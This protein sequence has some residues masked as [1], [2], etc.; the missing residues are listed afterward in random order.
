MIG[1][2]V[3]EK[4]M[5]SQRKSK[6]KPLQQGARTSTHLPF[7]P[8]RTLPRCHPVMSPQI[9]L[10]RPSQRVLAKHMSRRIYQIG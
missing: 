1:R 9:L 5:A 4:Q 6:S 8:C 10:Q 2:S 3:F 7:L